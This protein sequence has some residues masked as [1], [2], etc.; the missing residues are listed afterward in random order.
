[1]LGWPYPLA[2]KIQKRAVSGRIGIGAATNPP[3]C[4]K[5]QEWNACLGKPA[6]RHKAGESGSDNDYL[7]LAA[8]LLPAYAD[9]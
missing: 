1:M 9:H 7:D 3:A 8:T 4:L 6:S 5:Y 2:S